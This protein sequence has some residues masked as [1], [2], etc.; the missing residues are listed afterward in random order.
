[1]S[2]RFIRLLIGATMFFFAVSQYSLDNVWYFVR[3]TLA[4]AGCY[5]MINVIQRSNDLD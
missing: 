2:I 4:F 1:M 5:L 3:A